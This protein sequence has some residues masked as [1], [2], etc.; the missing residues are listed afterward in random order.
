ML[1]VK[2]MKISFYF[3]VVSNRNY[4]RPFSEVLIGIRATFI[5]NIPICL[6]DMI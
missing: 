4:M 2:H 6:S 5:K 1:N 3:T